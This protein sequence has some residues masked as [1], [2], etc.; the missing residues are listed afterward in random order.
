MLEGVGILEKV[1]VWGKICERWVLGREGGFQEG[2]VRQGWVEGV[3]WLCGENFF[4][5]KVNFYGL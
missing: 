5:F 4:N 3:R 1:D 2:C